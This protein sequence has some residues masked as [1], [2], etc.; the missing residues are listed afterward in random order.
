[1]ANSNWVCFDCRLAVRRPTQHE[2]TVACPECG[3]VC[4]PLGQKV[5]VPP[6]RDVKAWKSLHADSVARHHAFV[7]AAAKA[8]VRA[9][10][11]VE[12]EIRRLEAMPSNAGRAA[13]IRELKQR[14]A[15]G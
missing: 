14:L 13:A 12:L 8:R 7:D 11:D 4:W 3:E 2:G 15:K 5:P 10:H 1:M 9:R 6:Q